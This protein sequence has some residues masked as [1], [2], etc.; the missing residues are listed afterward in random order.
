VAVSVIPSR[1]ATATTAA[2]GGAEQEVGRRLGPLERAVSATAGG[3]AAPT[4]ARVRQVRA[5]LGKRRSAED[6]GDS[7]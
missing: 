2:F 4:R 7:D 6:A 3:L 1:S 5:G